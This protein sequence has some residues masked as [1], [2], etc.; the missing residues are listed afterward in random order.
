MIYNSPCHGRY[1]SVFPGLVVLH[2]LLKP[3]EPLKQHQPPLFR[4]SFCNLRGVSANQRPNKLGFGGQLG[5]KTKCCRTAQ[6]TQ[7]ISSILPESL[8]VGHVI[9][10]FTDRFGIHGDH[11]CPISLGFRCRHLSPSGRLQITVDNVQLMAVLKDTSDLRRVE[12]GLLILKT[13][14]L[15]WRNPVGVFDRM[16][17]YTPPAALG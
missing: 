8:G 16:L 10:A 15:A 13:A 14:S 7:C 1:G 6:N 11:R 2:G 9:P 4:S 17:F 3:V 12:Q 5:R